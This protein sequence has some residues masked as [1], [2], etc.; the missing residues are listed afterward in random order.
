MSGC[1]GEHLSKGWASRLAAHCLSRLAGRAERRLPESLGCRSRAGVLLWES[2][3]ALLRLLDWRGAWL[4]TGCPAGPLAVWNKKS[5]LPST[6]SCSTALGCE[7]PG[8]AAGQSM[9][10]LKVGKIG[11]GSGL[12]A[13]ADDAWRRVNSPRG[14]SRRP[15]NDQPKLTLTP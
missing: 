6:D 15:C 7:V 3:S 11:P 9:Q 10:S 12:W 5:A 4:A 2:L 14:L 8:L 1:Q 13:L